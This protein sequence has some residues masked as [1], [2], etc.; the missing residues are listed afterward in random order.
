MKTSNCETATPYKPVTNFNYRAPAELFGAP[1][2]QR[3]ATTYRRFASGAD[4]VRFAVEGIA[5]VL[6]A[7]ITLQVDDDRFDHRVIR[8]LYDSA[9][10]PLPRQPARPKKQ[11]LRLAQSPA[12]QAA[13]AG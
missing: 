10:Y 4:A 3:H 6:R 13:R 9:N 7:G 11:G 2:R 5:D 8:A 1:G 12:M